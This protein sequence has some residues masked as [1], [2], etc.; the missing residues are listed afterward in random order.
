[1][2]SVYVGTNT[3]NGTGNCQRL[4]V[5]AGIPPVQTSW[6]CVNFLI[7]FI[8]SPESEIFVIRIPSTDKNSK[9]SQ[10][11]HSRRSLTNWQRVKG[12]EVFN[13]F[14]LMIIIMCFQRKLLIGCR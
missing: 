4:A 6:S 2:S 13:E 1:M 5:V 14:L 8:Q 10:Y 11:C 12:K 7:L 9:P 3:R